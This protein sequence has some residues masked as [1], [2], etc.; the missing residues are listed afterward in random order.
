MCPR[1]LFSYN[2]QTVI[3][4]LLDEGYQLTFCR[5]FNSDYLELLN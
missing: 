2:L 4:S 3:E 5:D 1:Q